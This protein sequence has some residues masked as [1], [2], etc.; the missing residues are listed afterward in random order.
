MRPTAVTLLV[1]AAVA[2]GVLVAGWSLQAAALPA[3]ERGDEAAIRALTLLSRY[4]SVSSRFTIDDGA[5]VRGRC[6]EGW[7]PLDGRI[8]RGTML[9]LSD[10]SQLFA[11]SE[12][13][14]TPQALVELELA[15]CPRILPPRLE[16]LIQSGDSTHTTRAWAAGQPALAVRVR[17]KRA[18]TTLDVAPKRDVP[19]ALDVRGARISGRSRLRLP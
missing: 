14:L 2:G 10:G 15:G 17:A 5:A 12:S 11:A 4:R 9:R 18:T 13:H 3:P 19:L 7:F 8:T 16:Q 6:L 1:A